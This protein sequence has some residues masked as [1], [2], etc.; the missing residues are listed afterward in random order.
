LPTGMR[1]LKEYR[2]QYIP[3]MWAINGAFSVLGAVISIMLGIMFGS[4]EAMILGILIYL[5]ALAISYA[6]KKKTIVKSQHE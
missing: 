3:W 2:P 1:L 5:V 6:W 4:S